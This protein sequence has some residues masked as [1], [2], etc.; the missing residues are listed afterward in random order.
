MDQILI[1]TPAKDNFDF[2]ECTIH[3]GKQNKN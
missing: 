3:C 2:K 1:R